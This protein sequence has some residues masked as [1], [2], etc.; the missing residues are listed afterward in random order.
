MA[1][2]LT[3][4]V[5]L[6][7]FCSSLAGCTDFNV[8]HGVSRKCRQASHPGACSFSRDP[9]IQKIPSL[10]PKAS[11]YS[12][13]WATWIPRDCVAKSRTISSTIQVER[14]KGHFR[15]APVLPNMWRVS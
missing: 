5:C 15:K 14:L 7:V 8:E 6:C 10:G 12:L 1:R 13:H 2:L 3:G 9:S 11:R 4:S